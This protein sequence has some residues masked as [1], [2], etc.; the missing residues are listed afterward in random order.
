MGR[1]VIN[2]AAFFSYTMPSV[3]RDADRQIEGYGQVER[4]CHH[5]GE[6]KAGIGLLAEQLREKSHQQNCPGK[7]PIF[8]CGDWH[9]QNNGSL[10][11]YQHGGIYSV[12]PS[13]SPLYFLFVL[14]LM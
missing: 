10:E 12:E 9:L 13:N 1:D 6:S 7:S 14:I 2:G 8:E 3:Q 11:L 5:P 4:H